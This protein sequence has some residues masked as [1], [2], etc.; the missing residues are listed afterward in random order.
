MWNGEAMEALAAAETYEHGGC[1]G[2]CGIHR[3][4][5][6]GRDG[7]RM[8]MNEGVPTLETMAL[9]ALNAERG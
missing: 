6:T 8:G 2:W 3:R 4:C 7:K 9:A 1:S 5:S